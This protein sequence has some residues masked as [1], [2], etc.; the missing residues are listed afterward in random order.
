MGEITGLYTIGEVKKIKGK[1]EIKMVLDEYLKNPIYSGFTDLKLQT[2]AN[3]T[4]KP[5]A[6]ILEKLNALPDK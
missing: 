5:L 6:I 3:V 2:I 1:N 4:L